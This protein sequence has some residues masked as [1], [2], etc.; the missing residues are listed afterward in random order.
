MSTV[1]ARRITV[2]PKL[3]PFWKRRVSADGGGAT[4]FVTSE[5]STLPKLSW[6]AP[7]SMYP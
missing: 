4:L 3:D 6:S 1:Q 5:S 7:F 2:P